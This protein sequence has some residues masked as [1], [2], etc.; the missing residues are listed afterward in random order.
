LSA[1][2]RRAQADLDRFAGYGWQA[3]EL[4]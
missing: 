2:A 4:T 1:V 3:G